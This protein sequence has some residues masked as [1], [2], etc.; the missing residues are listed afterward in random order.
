MA[1]TIPHK[2]TSLELYA[3]ATGSDAVTR[4]RK[5]LTSAQVVV[6]EHLFHN[7]SHPTLQDREL[8]ARQA[9]MEVKAVTIWF[10][11][12][13]RTTSRHTR[14]IATTQNSITI[15]R[16]SKSSSAT[17]R[18]SST[19]TVSRR[20]SL[21]RVASRSE[22]RAS[23][24]RT[25]SRRH[26]FNPHAPLWANMTSSPLGP[27]SS[28]LARDYVEFGQ[29]QGTHTLEWACAR[30]RLAGKDDREEDM[31]GLL[32][33]AGGDTDVEEVE[34]AVTPPSSCDS[35]WSGGKS[36]SA[37]EPDEDMMKAALALCGLMQ[38]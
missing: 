18:A 4:T 35:S 3:L 30:R 32:E 31:P 36:A 15:P 33:D 21:D 19:S 29:G 22:L 20:P 6:L 9:D 24:P 28:P 16:R 37:L 13:R 23:V 7:T 12:K 34:E 5:R 1:A 38:G 2:S 14:N 11:N 8:L 10:Q 25:P 26:K 17:S 27:H